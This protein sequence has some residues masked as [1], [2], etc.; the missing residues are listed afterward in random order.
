MA[1]V[2]VSGTVTNDDQRP[3][4]KIETLRGKT[5]TEIH[6]SQMEVCGVETVDRS[7]ISR[8]AQSFREGRL[9]I[10]NDPKSGR[11]RTSTDDQSVER[12]LQILEGDRRMTCEEIA[13]CAGIS[14]ASAYRI[15]TERLHKRRT[16]ARWVPHDLSEEQKRRRV[17]IAQQLLH[18]FREEGNEF[19]QKVVPIDETWIRDFEPEL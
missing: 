7:T 14:R 10:E 8:W 5:P 4:I 2:R 16:A 18:R 3:Y 1:A 17:E 13:H 12:V 19:L 15:L 9:S 6:S 11:P